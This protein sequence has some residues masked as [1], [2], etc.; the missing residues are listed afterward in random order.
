MSV[1]NVSPE[2]RP[3]KMTRLLRL[4]LSCLAYGMK[5]GVYLRNMG[6]AAKAGLLGQ[7]AAA[8]EQAAQN[9]AVE[10]LWLADHIAIPPDDA[11]GSQGR[12]LDPLATLA[13]LAGCTEHVRLGVATLVLPYRT[14][15]PTAKWVATIQELSGNRMEL[16][17]G[18]GWMQA[19]F[20]A[21]GVDRTKRGRLTDSTLEF[22][23]KA[24]ADDVMEAN[25]Q[26]FLFRPRPPRPPILVG[27]GGHHALKRVLRYGDGWLPMIQD[28]DRLESGIKELDELYAGTDRPRPRIVGIRPLPLDD[29]PRAA[30]E[31]AR[32]AQMG[33]TEVI[34]AWRYDDEQT[35]RSGLEA[36]TALPVP[37]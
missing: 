15:L 36:L 22:L 18:A 26:P 33:V 20:Q 1:R 17:I 37:A 4:Q 10:A 8:L 28:F 13:F 24:F 35:F 12:Y 9:T 23:H 29:P 3:G 2:C 19:E 32:M 11:E 16:G 6:P 5:L 7:C 30:E 14:P 34:H 21:L 27:G 25:G 31:L